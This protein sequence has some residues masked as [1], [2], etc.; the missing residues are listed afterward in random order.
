MLFKMYFHL[1]RAIVLYE[2][3]KYNNMYLY[4]EPIKLKVGII[5][6]WMFKL[7]IILKLVHPT[8]QINELFCG[9]YG[10]AFCLVNY[11]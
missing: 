10:F 6:Y 1:Y 3:I 9:K 2:N 7:R 5:I 8:M 4:D 11:L